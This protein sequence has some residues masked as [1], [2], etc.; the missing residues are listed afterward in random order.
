M[1][2]KIGKGC[3]ILGAVFV[4]LALALFVYNLWDANRAEQEVAKVLQKIENELKESQE[5]LVLSEYDREMTE[6]TIDGYEYIGYLSIP[7]IGLKNP[8]MSQWSYAGLKLAPGRFWGATFSDD[9]V[10]A[11]HNYKSH[12]GLIKWLAIE[13]EVFFIDMNY[14]VWKYKVVDIETFDPVQVEEMI[15]K[16][17][18]SEWDLT[19][20]TCNIDGQT[21]CAV[22][23]AR[24][25]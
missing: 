21:R 8:I 11:G 13:T 3:M 16:T 24:I 23:C 19:L 20:F 2:Y 6:V 4:G 10:L 14:R 12:F 17:E 15:T 1:R 5:E 25:N 18:V 9:L 7:S 22:R